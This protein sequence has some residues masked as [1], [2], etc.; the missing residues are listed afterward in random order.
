MDPSKLVSIVAPAGA[1]LDRIGPLTGSEKL[2]RDV[3]MGIG[4]SAAGLIA[5]AAMRCLGGE[6]QIKLAPIDE[7]EKKI[8][9]ETGFHNLN[10]VYH[11]KDLAK[12]NDIMFAATG[13]TDGDVLNGVAYRKDGATTHSMVMRSKTKT[14][15]FSN[16]AKWS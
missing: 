15:R 3:L 8:L 6:I 7:A 9:S 1:G 16:A 11:T 14:R 12:G 4:G 5:A 13:I 2:F 10:Q